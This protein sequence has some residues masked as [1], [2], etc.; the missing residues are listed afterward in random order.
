MSSP[1]PVLHRRENHKMRIAYLAPEFLPIRG[2]V[3]AY[4]AELVTQ[5]GKHPDLEIHVITPRRKQV[6]EFCVDELPYTIH[7]ISEAKDGFFYNL[8]FQARMFTAFRQ[9]HE[10]HG[11]DLVHSAN[12]VH[13]P[14]IFLKFRELHVPSI[15]TVHT[16]IQSQSR[17]QGIYPLTN[18]LGKKTRVEQMTSL[19][20]PYIR[21]MEKRYLNKTDRFI[22]V[23][24]WIKGFLPEHIQQNTQVIHNGVD[25]ARFTPRPMCEPFPGIPDTDN[26]KI[27]F[28]GRLLALK[29]L[30]TLIDAMPGILERADAHIIFA[31]QGDQRQWRELLDKK[32]VSPQNYSF[33]GHVA[34]PD[35]HQLYNAAD[36]FV[37]PSYTESFPLTLLEAMASGLAC[38]AT[39]VGGIHEMITHNKDGILIEPAQPIELEHALVSL[40]NNA[41]R[42]EDIA[43]QARKTV[44]SRFDSSQMAE[45]TLHAYRALVGGKP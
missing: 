26:P 34:Y 13:M 7:Y 45:K 14:D 37:L 40:I 21:F 2:G 8:G 6:L 17:M 41:S 23:S 30:N 15:V 20:Y 4:S 33:I 39:N 28:C 24:N 43:K 27:L 36:I 1:K 19:F 5:L 10:T 38:V 9:L 25:T 18:G 42:R 22:A 12:L 29:G 3:G 35:V 32:G 16:T 31:G 11:F 44:V